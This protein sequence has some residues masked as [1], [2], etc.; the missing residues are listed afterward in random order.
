M[1]HQLF[2]R[3]AFHPCAVGADFSADAGVATVG[4]QPALPFGHDLP[5]AVHTFLLHDA[6]FGGAEWATLVAPA[7]V[8]PSI[9]G[10]LLPRLV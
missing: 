5:I 2:L 7:A 3:R 6:E 8:A 9:D 10:V 1:A 4:Q